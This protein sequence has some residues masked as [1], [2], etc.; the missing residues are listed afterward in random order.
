MLAAMMGMPLYV[1]FELRNVKVL[2][3]STWEEEEE[4]GDREK[5]KDEEEEGEEKEKGDAEG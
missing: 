1:C 4:E 2:C 3:R 5:K